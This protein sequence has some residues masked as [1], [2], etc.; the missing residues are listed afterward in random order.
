[1]FLVKFIDE[2]YLKSSKSFSFLAI[3]ENHK[4][5]C[6]P[7]TDGTDFSGMSRIQNF[8][9]GAILIIYTF[10]QNLRFKKIP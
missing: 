6:Y 9:W 4:M 5:N 10:M 8:R 7:V 2:Q 3:F 1:M